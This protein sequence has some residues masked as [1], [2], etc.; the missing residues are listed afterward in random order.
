MSPCSAIGGAPA[1][2]PKVSFFD[3]ASCSSGDFPRSAC[4][5]FGGGGTDT[6]HANSTLLASDV[7]RRQ[8]SRDGFSAATDQMMQD[9]DDALSKFQAQVRDGSSGVRLADGSGK[10]LNEGG[11]WGTNDMIAL[12]VLV[13]KCVLRRRAESMNPIVHR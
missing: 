6:R 4:G 5:G 10:V 8:S 1:D 9:F 13:G 2:T 7:D 3:T 11:A 12:M